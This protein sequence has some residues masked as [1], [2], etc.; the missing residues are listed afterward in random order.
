MGQSTSLAGPQARVPH[1]AYRSST[2]LL[3][4]VKLA[5]MPAGFAKILSPHAQHAWRSE[6]A[7]S[8]GTGQS[9]GL[10]LMLQWHITPWHAIWLELLDCMAHPP[11]HAYC[12][13]AVAL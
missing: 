4:I 5:Y 6:P 8:I 11:E 1:S 2:G 12:E 7:V 3:S 10:G 13:Q 9:S